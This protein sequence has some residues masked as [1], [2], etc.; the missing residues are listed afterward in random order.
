MSRENSIE[1][2]KSLIDAI[3]EKISQPDIRV[4]FKS[5]LEA[6]CSF[7]KDPNEL[8]KK[9][10][11]IKS[12]NSIA[13]LDK[14][15]QDR[16]VL[17]AKILSDALLT[18]QKFKEELLVGWFRNIMQLKNDSS[19][20]K[21]LSKEDL[22]YILP[23]KAFEIDAKC[24]Q[25]IE[26]EP[27]QYLFD[28]LS[29][30]ILIYNKMQ[31]KYYAPYTAIVQS[32][33]FGKTKQFEFLSKRCFVIYV[34]LS[35]VHSTSYPHRSR[36]AEFLLDNSIETYEEVDSRFHA[37]FYTYMN[38]LSNKQLADSPGIFK[39]C[40]NSNNDDL[41]G[42]I[43]TNTQIIK[44]SRCEIKRLKSQIKT[45]FVFDEARNLINTKFSFDVD[46]EKEI[47]SYFI[48][49][50]RT[51]KRLP[52][53]CFAIFTDTLSYL[54]NFIPVSNVDPSSR[55]SKKEFELFDPIYSIPTWDI[56]AKM[57][58]VTPEKLDSLE[59]IF[60]YGRPLWYAF[61]CGILELNDEKLSPNYV[62][63]LA[64]TKL[65]CNQNFDSPNIM[66]VEVALA[67][68]GC[69]S[70]IDIDPKSNEASLLVANYMR[71]C[72]YIDESRS[73]IYTL[74]SSEPILAEA[75]ALICH[76][77]GYY[78]QA[79]IRIRHAVLNG[80]ISQGK[81]GELTARIIL[82]M[83]NDRC[84][85]NEVQS[86]SMVFTRKVNLETFLKCMIGLKKL[87][88]IQ[89]DYKQNGLSEA[90]IEKLL[91]AVLFFNHFVQFDKAPSFEQL[92]QLLKRCGACICSPNQK[93]VDLILPILFDPLDFNSLGFVLIQIKNYKDPV[94]PK[95]AEFLNP[96]SLNLVNE[97]FSEDEKNLPF[98]SLYIELGGSNENDGTV[99]SKMDLKLDLKFTNK[100]K[101]SE[102][103]YEN[104]KLYVKRNQFFI[105][106]N[107]INANC[108]N[109]LLDN[110]LIELR[111]LCQAKNEIQTNL[112]RKKTA[113]KIYKKI[114]YLDF[115]DH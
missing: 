14:E 106:L 87:Q 2:M 80:V 71:I 112:K 105:Y 36:L 98:L 60:S 42:E 99:K 78:E 93:Y 53:N 75:S 49:L 66:P 86:S 48:I 51:L 1:I 34:S 82:L 83:A 96:F 114:A 109:F 32:S 10:L 103:E 26:S 28:Q 3:A 88:E 100:K 12:K 5:V 55:I 111:R 108:Y 43:I 58:E 15:I 74:Y 65:L 115:I 97:I 92:Q 37:Y 52:E 61:Y 76:D 46:S 30:Y 25:S 8:K 94:L 79:L 89:N 20:P 110:E 64:K 40:V 17:T 23:S 9:L 21:T 24:D 107:G 27:G 68:I 90:K 101:L 69:R 72:L 54:S 31:D 57:D 33:G 4:A 22:K 81:I 56:F 77:D 19:L 62:F 63:D 47:E 59:N 104:L 16:T 18:N 6:F 38:Y 84:P 39:N 102:I 67:L 35:S 41:I 70:Q 91:K 13:I 73:N 95:N 85:F 44:K 45:I 11:L 29:S 50:R 7:Y 113:L